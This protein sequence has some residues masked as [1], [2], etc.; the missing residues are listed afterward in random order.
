MSVKVAAHDGSTS[1]SQLLVG[2]DWTVRN[3]RR[4]EL[5]VR[6]LNLS[7]GAEALGSY[8]TDPLAAA[9][10]AAWARGIAVVSSGGNGGAAARGLDSP[11]FDPYVIAV[12]AGD[13]A[14]ADFSSRGS[15]SRAV[16]VVAPG[17]GIISARVPG[18]VLDENFPAARIGDTGFRGS[19]TSQAAAVVTGAV[20]RLLQVRPALAPDEVKA[21]LRASAAPLPGADRS[22]QGAGRVN[23][24][25][26][27]LA[28]VAGAWQRW[29]RAVGGDPS[30]GS[31]CSSPAP[32]SSGRMV[33]SGR[34]NRAEKRGAWSYSA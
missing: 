13:E 27:E 1:L 8:R 7:F 30:G 5:G 14:I 23:V 28:P 29:P 9:V 2:I 26:A 25:A 16:D 15:A 11:A 33:V 18:G 10:E 22:L 12:G 24:A 34:G 6:V 21:A 17:S 3:A 32:A 20:A 31:G 19:G 4:P